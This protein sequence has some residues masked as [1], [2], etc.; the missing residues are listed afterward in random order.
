MAH[1]PTTAAAPARQNAAER[2]RNRQSKTGQRRI[3]RGTIPSR[4]PA[5]CIDSTCN[6]TYSMRSAGIIRGS[7]PRTGPRSRSLRPYCLA[8]LRNIVDAAISMPSDSPAIRRSSVPTKVMVFKRI[9]G[10]WSVVVA[11]SLLGA[12]GWPVKQDHPA[13]IPRTGSVLLNTQI[14]GGAYP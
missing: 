6:R 13:H 7:G 14:K 11:T 5:S 3:T 2:M 10:S 1:N 12:R 4:A 9:H 8:T